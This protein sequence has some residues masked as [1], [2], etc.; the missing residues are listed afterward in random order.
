[1]SRTFPDR[2]LWGAATAAY[3]VEGSPLADGAGASIWHRFT[4]DPR[5]MIASGDTGDVACDHYNRMEGDVELMKQLGL[6]AYRFSISWSRILPEG[7]GRVNQAGLDFYR[8]LVDRLND[9]GI[10]PLPTLY[11]WDL[12]A[13]LDDRGGWL[14][15]DVAEWFGEYAAVMYRALDGEVRRWATLNEPWVVADGGYLNGVLAP[16]HRSIFECAIAS[17]NLMRAHGRAVQAYRETGRH[18]VGV[19]FNIEPKYP[20]SDRPED[21]AAAARADAYMNRQ[22]ADPALLGACPPELRDVYG[23]AWEDWSADDLALACQPVDFVG[24]NYYTRSVVRASESAWPLR[25]E[26]VV[27]EGAQHTETGWEVFPPAMTRTLLWF[28]ERYGEIPLYIMENGAAFAD[29]ASSAD[30]PIADEDRCR[31]LAA[32]IGA[33]H[34]AIAAGV[35]V[36]GYMVWS[37]FDN[38]EWALGYAKRFGIVHVDYD[39]LA[40]TPKK[41]ADLYRRIVESN[42]AAIGD[43]S[44]SASK[45]SGAG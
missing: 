16:G 44:S 43:V 3:Q 15:R 28:R 30:G 10:V 22:Y 20:A 17:R 14:N 36:R 41:S 38:L 5:L 13:A 6:Q 19:V 33:V 40:R 18:E 34:D 39:T 35:D 24:I 42:G 8:R 23:E 32:H 9:A 26:A 45:I 4:H 21:V 11:H 31:Y 7:T 37:L 12:P 29:P 25:A 1:M 27:Q 2:F